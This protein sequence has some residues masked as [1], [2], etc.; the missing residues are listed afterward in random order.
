MSGTVSEHSNAAVKTD[1]IVTYC[2]GTQCPSSKQAA[3][4]LVSLG[5]SIVF[6]YEGG[7][8]DWQEGGFPFVTL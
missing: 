1:L 2:G 8:Q 6:A 4:K 5:Y 7:L 3:E